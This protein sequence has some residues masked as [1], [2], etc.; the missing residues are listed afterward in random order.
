MKYILHPWQLFAVILASWINRQQ[1]EVIEYLRT[2]NAVFKEKFGKKRILL[3]DD[4]RRRLAVKGKVLGRKTL[5]QF[6]TL[7]TPETILHWHRQL[8]ANKWDYSDRKKKKHGRPRTRQAIVDLTIKFA[9]ENP[10]W[11]YDRISGALSNLGYNICDSTIGNILKSHGI[12]PTP[13]RKRTGSWETFLK[14]HWDVMAAI[15]FTTVEVWTKSGLTTFYLLS[16]MELKTRRVNFAG[17]TTNPNEAWMKTIASELTNDED[18]FLK[19]KKYLIMDR[20]ASFSKSF[21][22]FLRHEGVK[23]VR[24]PARSPNLNAHLERFFGSFDFF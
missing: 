16:V 10:T 21:R 15:D 2:E 19:D 23:P 6:G 11:A 8:V 14:A 1:Q 3:T 13:D 20:D 17:C 7:F 24:L 9:K 18:G 5:E 4:Q 12:E 22:N